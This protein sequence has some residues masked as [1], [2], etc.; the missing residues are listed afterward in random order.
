MRYKPRVA[1]G[2]GKAFFAALIGLLILFGAVAS[3]SA[4]GATSSARVAGCGVATLQ[5][6]G[7]SPFRV[8]VK[9]M[10]C[11]AGKRLLSSDAVTH[12]LAKST[13][14][15]PDSFKANGF[16]CGWDTHRLMC[17]VGK[18]RGRLNFQSFAND[19]ARAKR[20]VL[21]TPISLVVSSSTEFGAAVAATRAAASAQGQ[22]TSSALGAWKGGCA[23]DGKKNLPGVPTSHCDVFD[24][25]RPKCFGE[26]FLYRVGP[27][28]GRPHRW[29]WDVFGGPAAVMCN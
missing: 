15:P 6:G 11:K 20:A 9:G 16:S 27:V 5:A 7:S 4:S 10:S 18:T 17:W 12:E 25:K 2:N 1:G 19:V 22:K 3:L 28:A 29:H 24:T 13:I 14:V 23:S 26:V 21:S 8:W